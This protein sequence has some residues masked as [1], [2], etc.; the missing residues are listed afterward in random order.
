M[1]VYTVN[2]HGPGSLAEHLAEAGT[3]GL[4]TDDPQGMRRS[5]LA[6]SPAR[7]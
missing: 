1:L 3:S 6:R 4:F 2:D 5:F 7:V